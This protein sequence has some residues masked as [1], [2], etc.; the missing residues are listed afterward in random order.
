MMS[1]LPPGG[2]GA[3]SP[4]LSSTQ[5]LVSPD[6]KTL[7]LAQ[8]VL[9]GHRYSLSRAITMGPLGLLAPMSARAP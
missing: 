6:L 4:Y 5:V 8:G 9:A 7:E 1:V 2:A 3:D